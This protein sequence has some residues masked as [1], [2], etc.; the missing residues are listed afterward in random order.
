VCLRHK[1]RQLECRSLC[2]SRVCMT[3]ECQSCI[4]QHCTTTN[5]TLHTG[6]QQC[7]ALGSQLAPA[8]WTA[9][10]EWQARVTRCLQYC[11]ITVVPTRYFTGARIG[12]Q[13]LMQ[14]IMQ[15]HWG[16]LTRPRIGVS[17]VLPATVPVMKAERTS[18]S[19]CS[20]DAQSAN[21][22]A[23]AGAGGMTT[24]S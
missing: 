19:W 7:A 23:V 14:Y 10:A 8:T 17:A 3:F 2:T 20:L 12:A 21:E 24:G 13:V 22:L 1:Q 15:V 4:E 11:T 6:Q 18:Q 16:G 9:Q 5:K